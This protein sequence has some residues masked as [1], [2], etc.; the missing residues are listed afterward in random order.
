MSFNNIKTKAKRFVYKHGEI[1]KFIKWSLVTGIGASGIELIV[2]MLLLKFVFA[3]LNEVSITNAV[4]N[5]IGV[6]YAGYMY[7]YLISSTVGYTLAFILN[8]KIT[9]KANSN[10]AVS[11]VFAV[12]LVVI[13]IFA[14]A[15]IGSVLSNI[16]VA[17]HWG[18]MSDAIIKIITMTIPSIWIYPANRFIIHRVNKKPAAQPNT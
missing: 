12:I 18:S 4:L 14:S 10:P 16:S 2:H 7:S 11:A 8:R 15:W 3:S 13:N 17:H 5:F 1:W 9:F 6:Q